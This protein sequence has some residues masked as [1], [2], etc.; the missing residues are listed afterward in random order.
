VEI[1]TSLN[2]LESLDFDSNQITST[3]PSTLGLLTQLRTLDLDS[4]AL[5]GSLPLELFDL[6]QLLALDVD[7]N[8]LTGGLPTEMG[9][10]L[11]LQSI[12]IQ[13]NQ[14]SGTVPTEVGQLGNLAVLL[15]QKNSFTGSMPAEVCALR[16][17]PFGGLAGTLGTLQ[18]DCA[19]PPTP[20]EIQCDNE[21]CTR[22]FSDSGVLDVRLFGLGVLG[23]DV[24]VDD[25]TP[26][27]KMI[28]SASTSTNNNDNHSHTDTAAEDPT[29]LNEALSMQPGGR[30]SRSWDI[31]VP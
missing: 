18:S 4:N 8:L 14:F 27:S 1:G 12:Q 5:T 6:Q 3:I 30:L 16:Q 7:T 9:N 23:V 31:I 19:S 29:A 20:P 26:T 25:A 13:N 17:D 21:C 11:S 15:V 22:C 2:S 24:E 28:G 10:A